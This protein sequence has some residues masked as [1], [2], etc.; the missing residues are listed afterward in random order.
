MT[1]RK[2]D[3]VPADAPED[4]MADREAQQH[5]LAN[6]PDK[7][8]QPGLYPADSIENRKGDNTPDVAHPTVEWNA[9]IQPERIDLTSKD[10]AM[11]SPDIETEEH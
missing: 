7:E 11:A 6:A 10:G 5:D 2:P 1:D 3:E 4:A 8:V 9:R